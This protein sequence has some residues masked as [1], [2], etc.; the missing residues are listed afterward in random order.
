MAPC[1]VNDTTSPSMVL[2]RVN[3]ATKLMKASGSLTAG[4][5]AARC[6][7]LVRLVCVDGVSVLVSP[8]FRATSFFAFALFCDGAFLAAA[9]FL[10]TPLG[11]WGLAG[12]SASSTASS[13]ALEKTGSSLALGGGDA[14]VRGQLVSTGGA[15]FFEAFLALAPFFAAFLAARA[16]SAALAGA[17]A[18]SFLDLISAVAARLLGPEWAGAA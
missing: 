11:F 7:C 9:V 16:N 6:F 10:E 2:P 4:G 14:G 3:A 17:D 5:G 18:G 13:I 8:R 15:G 1:D 12:W